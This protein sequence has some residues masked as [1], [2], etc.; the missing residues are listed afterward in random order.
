VLIGQGWAP[1]SQLWIAG[2][3]GA[4]VASIHESRSKHMSKKNKP[5]TRKLELN[6]ETLVKLDD[7]GQVNGG[8]GDGDIVITKKE[9]GAVGGSWFACCR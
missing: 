3:A 2:T 1:A 9:V 7:L 5:P 4:F 6:K 8:I